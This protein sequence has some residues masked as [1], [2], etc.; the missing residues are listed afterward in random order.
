LT[1]GQG[2]RPEVDVADDNAD[3]DLDERDRDAG[4]DGDQAGREGQA[5]YPSFD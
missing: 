3:H 1:K 2:G 4:A 5:L